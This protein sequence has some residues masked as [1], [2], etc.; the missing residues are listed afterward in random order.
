MSF[1]NKILMIGWEYP[2]HNSGGLGTACDGMT[3]ALAKQG[4]E[5]Y[6]T[7]PYKFDAKVNHMHV[8]DCYDPS[9]GNQEDPP[10][11]AYFSF[12]EYDFLDE[13]IDSFS[14]ASLPR[15]Q[16]EVK[17]QKYT[18][19]VEKAATKIKNKFDVIHAHDWMSFPAGIKV[20]TKLKKPFIAHIHSTEYDRIPNGHGSPYI[21]ETEYKGMQYADKIISVSFYTKQLLVKKYGIDPKKIEVVHNGFL[22]DSV[23]EPGDHH[24]APKRP[25]VVFMGRLTAQKGIHFFLQVARKVLSVRKDVLF[26]IAGSGDMYHELIFSTAG[27]GLSASV[28]FSGFV[29]KKQKKMLL[30]RADIFL[31]PSISEPFGLVATEAAFHHT[32]VIVSKNSG[33]KEVLKS[34]IAI[35]FWDVDLMSK[36]V[37]DLLNNPSKKQEIIQNQLKDLKNITWDKAATKLKKIYTSLLK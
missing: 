18:D 17:V 5:I 37:L 25:V 23:P 32:P 26:V 30:D 24:F 8:I 21:M 27:Q 14:L 36:T 6:F 34:A 4:T 28:L 3:K 13:S 16:I 7:L 35:D 12:D 33:V 31:M 15:S 11:D 10:F 9:W 19:L 22:P 2:P 1:M 29:R 20:K